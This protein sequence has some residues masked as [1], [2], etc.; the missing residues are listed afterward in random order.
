MLHELTK[1]GRNL[2][3]GARL[4]FFMPVSRLAFRIDLAQLLLLFVLSALLDIGVDWMRFRPDARFSWFGAGSEFLAAGMLL[5]C[6][7][8]LALL[9]RQHALALAIPLLA[10]SAYPVIQVVHALGSV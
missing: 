1:L 6:S 2:A 10:L 9:F 4:A 3:A 5:F 7:A 8:V